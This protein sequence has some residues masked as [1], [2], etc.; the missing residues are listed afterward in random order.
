M[1]YTAGI[2]VVN[3]EVVRLAEF[4]SPNLSPASRQICRLAHVHFWLKN[5]AIGSWTSIFLDG[6]RRV[7]KGIYRMQA[8]LQEKSRQPGGTLRSVYTNSDFD[9]VGCDSRIQR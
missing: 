9:S 5:W 7:G 4:F 8:E 2:D 1:Y 6:G 3:L